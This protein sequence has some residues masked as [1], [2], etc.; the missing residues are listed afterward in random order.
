VVSCPEGFVDLAKA[1]PEIERVMAYATAA[2]FTGAPLPGYSGQRAW[3]HE[4]CVPS[5]QEIV[6]E[7]DAQGY[8]LRL[9]DAYRPAQAVEAMVA[10]AHRAGRGDLLEVGYLSEKSRHSK[11][12]AVDVSLV[13]KRTGQAL[14][15]G[16]AWDA[17]TP[18][19]YSSWGSGVLRQNR[20]L[21]RAPFVSRG[22][23]AAK[24]EWWH[25]DKDQEGL[26][27]LDVSYS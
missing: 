24:T 13:D 25:F 10:W 6:S 27:A 18:H 12:C 3:L 20:D 8:R 22:W 4:S 2:N 16:T 11:G 17:F 21:L 23:R 26:L 5:L 9:Y 19:S 15:M 14:D 7:L 1:C